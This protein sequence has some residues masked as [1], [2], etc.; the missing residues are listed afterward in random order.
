M[1][2]KQKILVPSIL[3]VVGLCLLTSCEPI[4][5]EGQQMEKPADTV[6]K[7]LRGYG[8]LKVRF[9]TVKTAEGTCDVWTFGAENQE[10]ASIAVGKLLADMTLSPGVKRED[11]AIDGIHYPL[12]TV[13][14]GASYSGFVIEKTGYVLST[15]DTARLKRLLERPS[16]L[17][18]K[19][20][21]KAVTTLA[22]PQFLDRFDRYGWGFYGIEGPGTAE[23]KED[24]AE[25][26]AFCAKHNFRI[27]LWPQPANHSDSFS[28]TAWESMGWRTMEARKLGVP[29]SARLYGGGGLNILPIR[30]ELSEL[31]QLPLPWHDGGWYGSSLEFRS[32]PQQSW[33]NKDAQLYMA[34]QTQEQIRGL[35]RIAPEVGSWMLPYGEL[36][37]EPWTEFH[38]DRSPA[39]IENWRETL[40]VRNNL[41]IEEVSKMYH[42]ATPFRSWNEVPIP[43]FATFFGLDGMVKSLDNAWYVRPETTADQGFK[44]EWWKANVNTTDWEKVDVPGDVRVHKYFRI[45]KWF[46]REFELKAGELPEKPIYLYSFANATN[47]DPR[48]K[49]VIYLNGERVGEPGTWGAWNVT[50]F[51]KTGVNRIAFRSPTEFHGHVFLSVDR[52]AVYPYLGPERN[53][54]FRIY[55]EWAS[56]IGKYA[57]AETVLAGMRQADP[58]RPIKIMCMPMTNFD[59]AERYGAFGHFTGEGMWFFPWFKRYGFLYNVPGTSEGGGPCDTVEQMQMLFQRVFLEGLNAHDQ[60]FVVQHI[61][62]RPALKKWWDEHIATLK[63]LGRYDISGP[64]VVIYRPINASTD[65]TPVPVPEEAKALPVQKVWDWDIGRGT[66][67][68]IGHSYLYADTRALQEGKVAGYPILMD[69]GNEVLTEEAVN[70]IHDWVQQGGTYITWPFTGRC[71]PDAPDSWPISKLTGCTVKTLRTPGKGNVIIGKQQTVFT[72]L[73]GKT[74]PDN[75][76]SKD[77]QD[78]EHNLVSTELETGPGL[79]SS[80]DVR[81]RRAGD[82]RAEARQR[83]RHRAGQRLLP[84]RA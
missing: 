54:L 12:V 22:Y 42:V 4:K 43:E 30:K 28:V 58:D 32:A 47:T 27:E 17:G 70:L 74:F 64:Q 2:P 19:N 71:L 52:P 53:R 3:M 57:S 37:N 38:G 21:T 16:A 14:G 8:T 34:R 6:S 35:L 76:S 60:V 18:I 84:R 59:L 51:L 31:H 24:P 23:P 45:K 62:R 67:Q 69:C 75:G 50:K 48:N 5:D 77:W 41:S 49:A 29:I 39:A 26:L 1:T 10:K 13:D 83:P 78:F 80:G 33:Y 66:L 46:I 63:Q 73:A 25:D 36:A 56:Y 55:T 15:D 81:E 9:E 44:E 11:A 79:R 82:R 72:E 7:R 20:A 40:R 61:T 68:S 65:F